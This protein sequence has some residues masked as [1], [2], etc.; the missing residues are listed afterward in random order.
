MKT[1]AWVLLLAAAAWGQQVA[2]PRGGS[3]GPSSRL[4]DGASLSADKVDG[5]HSSAMPG[6]NT[7]AVA[8][9]NGKLAPGWIPLPT[10][11][12][13]GGIFMDTD[14]LAG[15]HVNRIDTASGRL[16]CSADGGEWS[17]IGNKPA[18][19]PPDTSSQAWQELQS[20][21]GAK[22][23][24]A[25]LD[26]PLI[27][28]KFGGGTCSGYLKSDGTCDT[29]S[30][31]EST[32]SLDE[33][34]TPGSV[35]SSKPVEVAGTQTDLTITEGTPVIVAGENHWSVDSATHRPAYSYNGGAANRVAFVG[36]AVPKSTRSAP[37]G[38][39]MDAA[40][41]TGSHVSDIDQTTGE[42]ACSADQG[43]GFSGW[44]LAPATTHS[45]DTGT[46]SGSV[47]VTIGGCSGGTAYYST[48]NGATVNEYVSTLTFSGTTTLVSRCE[49][50]HY[51][52]SAAKTSTYTL[53]SFSQVASD[54]FNRTSASTL[55]ANWTNDIGTFGV[56]S[57]ATAYAATPGVGSQV[58][59]H[60]SAN[61]FNNRQYSEVKLATISTTWQGSGPAIRASAAGGYV[62][63]AHETNK[64]SLMKL[65]AGS[66]GSVLCSTDTSPATVAAGDVIRIEA[67]GTTITVKRTSGT[68]ATLITCTDSSYSTGAAGVGAYDNL[69]GDLDDWTGGNL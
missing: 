9:G 41:A 35:H 64:L 24:A 10:S 3:L 4:S 27:I 1:T 15:N 42:L 43:G 8:E 22:L 59:A 51:D 6:A 48:D 37:G 11:S 61:S 32:P 18:A 13:I 19:F 63:Y 23:G 56:G 45:P 2:V 54:D 20:E 49:K 69:H 65:V 25:A 40:C 31:S 12:S 30:G 16:E 55:G 17:A 36:D 26:S 67:D 47:E 7:G 21:V 38:T 28:S 57:N 39:Y 44:F 53:D 46:Y 33:T 5:S 58:L 29:P 52:D 34:S 68:P 66:A 50:G 62:A 60:W 14:C